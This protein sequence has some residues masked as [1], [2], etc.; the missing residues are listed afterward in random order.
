MET[1]VRQTHVKLT[2]S[3]C[4]ARWK[5][6]EECAAKSTDQSSP[7]EAWWTQWTK[8]KS[9]QKSVDQGTVHSKL[10]GPK[11]SPIKAQWTKTKSNQ[12]SINQ[13]KAQS[14][15]NGPK[16]S[17]IKAQWTKEKSNQNSMDQRKVQSKLNGPQKSPIKTQWTKE[18]AEN[19]WKLLT[20]EDT[21]AN[22]FSKSRTLLSDFSRTLFFE[23]K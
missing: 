5:L 10:N 18:K 6:A 1:L 15:L 23:G 8:V 16:K 17:P 19:C 14:K 3:S 2:L 9:N 12:N 21:V 20:Q 11:K 22:V 7:V 13:R 4:K